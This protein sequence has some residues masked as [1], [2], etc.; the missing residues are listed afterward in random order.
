MNHGIALNDDNLGSEFVLK[1]S[2]FIVVRA[3]P[4]S[5]TDITSSH[6]ENGDDDDA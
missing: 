1:S 6:R 4:G 2:M 3:A 5:Y